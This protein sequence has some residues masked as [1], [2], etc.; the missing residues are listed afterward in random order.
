VLGPSHNNPLESSNGLS[1]IA[2]V[3]GDDAWAVG[4]YYTHTARTLVEHWNG[5]FWNIVPSPNPPGAGGSGSY[6]SAVAKTSATDVWAV[7]YY[8]NASNKAQTLVERWNGAAWNIDSSPNQ[9]IGDNVLSSV[10]ALSPNDVWAVGYYSNASNVA[11]TLV[12]HW[13]GSNWSIVPSPNQGSGPNILYGVAAAGPADVWA[14]GSQAAG[15]RSEPLAEHWNGTAWT[16]VATPGPGTAYNEL[17][18]VAVR[19]SSDIWAVGYYGNNVNVNSLA[20]LVEHWNGTAWSVVPSPN[21]DPVSNLSLF[22]GVALTGPNDVWAAGYYTDANSYYHTLVEHWNG[23]IWGVVASPDEGVS[24]DLLGVAATSPGDAWVVGQYA[25]NVAETVA[26]LW[27]GTAWSIVPSPNAGPVND[28]YLVHVTALSRNNVWAVG[29][30]SDDSNVNKTLAQHWD[31]T[32]WS[33]TPSNNV[34]S[35]RQNV[36]RGIAAATTNDVWA[37]GNYVTGNN[38]VQ[39]LAEHWD[40]RI[41]NIALTPNVGSGNNDLTSVAVVAPNDVWAVGDY[42][43]NNVT[44][45]LVEHWDGGSWSVVPSPNQ[46]SGDNYLF[47]VEGV[48]AN[49]IWAVG[50]VHVGSTD[51]TLIEH[52]NGNAWA[53]VAS[54]NRGSFSNELFGMAAAAT[55]DVWAVGN[56]I[57]AN[58]PQQTLVEHWNGSAWA[59]V[60]SPSPISGSQATLSSVARAA[61]NDMWAVGS[62]FDA[63]SIG[64][65]LVEHWDGTA[66]SIVASEDATPYSSILS[67]AAIVEPNDVWAVG[68]IINNGHYQILTERYNPCPSACTLTFNDVPAGS[69][70]Y[71]YVRCLGCQGIISGYQCGGPGEPCPGLYFRPGNAVTRGQVS[72]F[73]VNAAGFQNPIPPNRQSFE[74]V[75]S[76]NP[77]WLYV[78]RLSAQGYI[79]GYPCG[80]AP[81]GPC[82]PPDNRPYFLP[83]NNVTRGQLAKIAANASGYSTPP[84]VQTFEDVPPTSSFYAY[85]E[86]VV[87]HRVISGYPCG[88][89][90]AGPCVPPDNRPY[91]VPSHNVTRGQTA[92]I[93][94][95]TFFPDCQTPNTPDTLYAPEEPAAHGK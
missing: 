45:T 41:W 38:V 28:N 50:R 58:M 42:T 10:T 22:T 80:Q 64:H 33:D 79:S 9:G 5:S 76:A 51:R 32:V 2:V 3:A 82:V 17:N 36:F 89:A 78:E 73:V 71:P 35:A 91:Y 14:V 67:G 94:S 84:S 60:N 85:V 53:I 66:W 65:T 19:S 87:L 47:D 88:Q 4:E 63:G 34:Q 23:S 54:P 44:Q 81:A 77:F 39:T 20:P 13:D 18:G 75:P 55:N 68:Y 24:A 6:L 62:Y 49:D 29:S 7:G 95:N 1:G 21:P 52:W 12:Q 27:N 40:G 8:F 11:Q 92:K 59:V 90:P 57:N 31:G 15:S 43:N 70:F 30:Y 25:G 16:I 86:R 83:G 61:G 26:E 48:M 74:D 46:G 72:K 37:V 56:Y 69:T 93:V